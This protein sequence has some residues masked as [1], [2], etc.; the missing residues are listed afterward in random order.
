MGRRP[1]RRRTPYNATRT[2]RAYLLYNLG[3]LRTFS[4]RF[5][6]VA[7]SAPRRHAE[8]QLWPGSPDQRPTVAAQAYNHGIKQVSLDFAPHQLTLMRCFM[9]LSRTITDLVTKLEADLAAAHKTLDNMGVYRGDIKARLDSLPRYSVVLCEA[10]WTNVVGLLGN[11]E[12]AKK[13]ALSNVDDVLPR[14]TVKVIDRAT[15]NVVGHAFC[16]HEGAA[17]WKDH[18]NG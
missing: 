9:S 15:G 6:A 17:D 8:Q 18:N 1:D 4:A 11:L 2:K 12:R 5:S 13:L 16:D 14:N 3:N 10:G 7:G